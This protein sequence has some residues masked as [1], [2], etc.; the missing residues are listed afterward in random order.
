MFCDFWF[1]KY[2]KR[3]QPTVLK[4]YKSF[5]GRKGELLNGIQKLPSH[6][7]KKTFVLPK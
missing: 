6:I 5:V 4:L 1:K 2:R 3:C 7:K